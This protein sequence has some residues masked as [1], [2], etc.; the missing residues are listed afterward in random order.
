MKH[1]APNCH[2][3]FVLLS[4]AVTLAHTVYLLHQLHNL[5][6]D[7]SVLC[8]VSFIVSFLSVPFSDEAFSSWGND[9]QFC[10]LGF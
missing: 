7:L 6:T 9:G 10:A 3:V 2:L 4:Q 1:T 5:Q 8:A